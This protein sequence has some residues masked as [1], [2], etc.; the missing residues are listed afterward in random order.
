[1]GV[2]L[3]MLIAWR[4]DVLLKW[5]AIFSRFLRT[6]WN[7]RSYV[8]LIVGVVAAEEK[9]RNLF[10]VLN[11][12]YGPYHWCNIAHWQKAHAGGSAVNLFKKSN[13]SNTWDIYVLQILSCLWRWFE[14]PIQHFKS[15]ALRS[16]FVLKNPFLHS[17]CSEEPKIPICQEPY[18][19]VN[20]KQ[21]S[22]M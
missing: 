15:E 19:Y 3:V 14:T 10:Q 9:E 4:R 12:I 13:L 21:S 1:M 16:L 2:W 11:H 8:V 20:T 7:Q 6:T 18:P 22:K 17:H 5:Q